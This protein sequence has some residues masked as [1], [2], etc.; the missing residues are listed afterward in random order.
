VHCKLLVIEHRDLSSGLSTG[1]RLPASLEFI[2]SILSYPCFS[3]VLKLLFCDR[4]P[5]LSR[6]LVAM[7]LPGIIVRV[8]PSQSPSHRTECVRVRVRVR[9]SPSPK[10]SEFESESVRVRVRVRPS[11]SPSAS[12]SEYECVRVR[13][14]VRPSPSPT[15]NAS[16]SESKCVRVRVRVQERPSPPPFLPPMRASL[17]PTPAPGPPPSPHHAGAVG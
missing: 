3:L 9:P 11:P 8:R 4:K 10:A 6:D 5:V 2:L 14:R 1:C 12:E 17:G 15:R 16:E 7:L 13:V